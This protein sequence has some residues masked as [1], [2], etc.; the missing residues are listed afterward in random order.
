L[1][2]FQPGRTAGATPSPADAVAHFYEALRLGN[3]DA[4]AGLL[5]DKARAETAKNG[6]GISSSG[7]GSLKYQLGETDYVTEQMD[8]AHVKSIWTETDEFGQLVDT[9]VIWVLRKQHNGWRVAGMAT[10]VMEGQLPLLFNFED[11]QDMLQKKAFVE[12]QLT[13]QPD[14]SVQQATHTEAVGQQV[15]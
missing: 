9:E 11:P 4:I 3:K 1:G 2:V 8:G 12:N 7:S 14:T 13:H 10:Q 5:T 6:L 15:R